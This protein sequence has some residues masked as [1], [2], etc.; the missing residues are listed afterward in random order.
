LEKGGWNSRLLS[1]DEADAN[2]DGVVSKAELAEHFQR[3]QRRL[4]TEP[5]KPCGA[6]REL[7]SAI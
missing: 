1:F 2:G 6:Q 5:A 7:V 4:D 3:L